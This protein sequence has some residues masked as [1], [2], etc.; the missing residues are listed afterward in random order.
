MYIKESFNSNEE[1]LEAALTMSKD[2]KT[3]KLLSNLFG[4]KPKL[5]EEYTLLPILKK[6]N[7]YNNKKYNSKQKPAIE[8]KDWWLR[9]FCSQKVCL[10][11]LIIM[12]NLL[13]IL[14]LYTDSGL[15]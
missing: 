15:I 13:F 9:F 5:E 1:D 2:L 3:K 12:V 10:I 14:Q 7:N 4:I 11:T 6:D 8:V